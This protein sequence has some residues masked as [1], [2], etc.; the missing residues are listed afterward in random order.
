MSVINPDNASVFDEG[1]I[2]VLD[3]NY[4][5]TLTDAVPAPGQAPGA[6]WLD[7]GLLGTEGVTYTPASRRHSSTAGESLASRARPAR[8]RSN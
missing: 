8:A 6:M 4:T 5:G 3:P 7:F 1:E 2:Y